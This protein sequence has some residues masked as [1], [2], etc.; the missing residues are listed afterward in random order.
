MSRFKTSIRLVLHFHSVSVKQILPS[1][2][3]FIIVEG[4]Y[5]PTRMISYTLYRKY[6][7][8]HLI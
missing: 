6:G 5:I 1:K 7:P 4:V 2:M 8:R 3:K